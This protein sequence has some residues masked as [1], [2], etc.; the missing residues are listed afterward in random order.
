MNS[1]LLYRFVEDLSHHF[2]RL[3][4]A[5][6]DVFC[7]DS[8]AVCRFAF[9]FE[10]VDCSSQLFCRDLWDSR[11]LISVVVMH[12][13]AA[14]I[15]TLSDFWFR[16]FLFI[17]DVYFFVEFAQDIG[18]PFSDVMISPLSFFILVMS[19][20]LFADLNLIPGMFLIPL[21]SSSIR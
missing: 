4:V 1:F 2:F 20:L 16:F 3:I 21:K 9:F 15:F 13:D 8:V 7:S 6:F 19:T 17:V 12:T 18:N 5:C 14:L 11:H 10:F